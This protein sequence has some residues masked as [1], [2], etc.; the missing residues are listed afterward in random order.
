MASIPAPAHAVRAGRPQGDDITIVLVAAAR[1]PPSVAEQ[2]FRH[3]DSLEAIFA[4]SCLPA[5]LDAEL[6]PSEFHRRGSSTWSGTTRNAARDRDRLE[7]APE[8]LTVR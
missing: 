2:S 4:S 1:R 3:F 5:P 6:P 8:Q 7:H